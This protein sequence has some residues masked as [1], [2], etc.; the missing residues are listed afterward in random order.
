MSGAGFSSFQADILA[1][2][3][4]GMQATDTEPEEV[5]TGGGGSAQKPTSVLDDL[6]KKLRDVRKNQ[7]EVT[8]GWKESA[9]KLNELFGSG[10]SMSVFSGIEQD[11]RNL[12][13]GEDIIPKHGR[14]HHFL[15]CRNGS[16]G[17]REEKERTLYV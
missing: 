4:R 2:A 15:D 13:M 16:R 9:D 3:R 6:T 1:K 11:M 5:D 14:R 10:K 12:N 17:V 7:I 8:N